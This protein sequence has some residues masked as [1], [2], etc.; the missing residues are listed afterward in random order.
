M[1]SSRKAIWCLQ[2]GGENPH[3]MFSPYSG[4]KQ[5]QIVDNLSTIYM[6]FMIEALWIHNYHCPQALLS[7]AEMAC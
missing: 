2:G 5:R 1:V 6:H 4:G 7:A 3:S